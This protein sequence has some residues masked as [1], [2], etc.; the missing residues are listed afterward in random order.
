M[1]KIDILYVSS[2]GG[3]ASAVVRLLTFLIDADETNQ[4]AQTRKKSKKYVQVWI[5]I[6]CK[7]TAKC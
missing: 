5:D 7:C 6:H 3:K 2:V 1:S 4:S